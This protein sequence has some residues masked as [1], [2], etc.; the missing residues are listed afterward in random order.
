MKSKGTWFPPGNSVADPNKDRVTSSNPEDYWSLGPGRRRN[1]KTVLAWN[2]GGERWAH[3]C[4]GF[5]YPENMVLQNVG[6][7]WIWVKS[8]FSTPRNYQGIHT[9]IT[10]GAASNDS[11]TARFQWAS[12]QL[13]H[14]PSHPEVIISVLH[15]YHGQ[16]PQ[17]HWSSESTRWNWH[18]LNHSPQRDVLQHLRKI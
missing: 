16:G 4:S 2:D 11:T 13:S 5:N 6:E 1:T 12:H 8:I 15:S 10:T 7:A 14:G 9:N 3:G 18:L 17:F